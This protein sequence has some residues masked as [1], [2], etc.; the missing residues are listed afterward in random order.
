METLTLD[1][2]ETETVKDIKMC[3]IGV[4]K[5]QYTTKKAQKQKYNPKEKRKINGKMQK[6]YKRLKRKT[7]IITTSL[8]EHSIVY[9]IYTKCHINTTLHFLVILVFPSF[10][11]IF[12]FVSLS[13]KANQTYKAKDKQTQNKIK[14]NK[15]NRKL[16][17]S[18]I[19][20]LNF[21]HMKNLQ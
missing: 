1:I 13:H 2:V 10:A 12:F 9:Y 14:T 19:S 18:K 15:Y 17:W 3:S 8:S 6:L 16:R 4:G 21:L 20:R 11:P 7:T 5:C